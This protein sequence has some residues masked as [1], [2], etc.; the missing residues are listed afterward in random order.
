[1]TDTSRLPGRSDPG[2]DEAASKVR[3]VARETLPRHDRGIDWG[4]R[5]RLIARKGDAVRLFVVEGHWH[6]ACGVRGFGR[7]Y[8]PAVLVLYRARHERF[9]GHA[10]DQIAKGR[11]SR[12]TLASLATCIDAAFGVTGLASRLDPAR[13]AIV[14]E[15]ARASTGEA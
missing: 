15:Q 6:A 3:F 10:S 11:I 14:E 9:A 12:A 7:V 1:M 4:E 5:R 8:A 2:V 13:T